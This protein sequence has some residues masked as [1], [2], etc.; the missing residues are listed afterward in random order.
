MSLGFLDAVGAV[1]ERLVGGGERV[2]VVAGRQLWPTASSA[3]A[4]GEGWIAAPGPRSRLAVAAGVA[5]GGWTVV[6]RCDDPAD[7]R[8]APWG[9]AGPEGS[10]VAVTE[11]VEVASAAWEAGATVLEP[12]WP[13]DVGPLLH[14]A[15]GAGPVCL[16]LHG[17]EVAPAPPLA[18]DLPS[19]AG[20]RTVT[21]GEAGTVAAA[22]A[23]VAPLLEAAWHLAR[24]GRPITT[25]QLTCLAGDGPSPRVAAG[26][27]L[28]DAGGRWEPL[29]VPSTEPGAVGRVLASRLDVRR[30]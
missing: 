15:A 21:H 13:A 20:P 30:A 11:S 1:V 28:W 9:L 3:G 26:S 12:A 6:A 18:L 17:A 22:G 7:A 19:L 23:L 5:L 4:A 25:L 2:A 14:A 8:L 16:H 24:Q 29:A 10:L 27:L